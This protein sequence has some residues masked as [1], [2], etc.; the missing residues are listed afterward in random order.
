LGGVTNKRL[1]GKNFGRGRQEKGVIPGGK[2]CKWKREH[3]KEF[4]INSNAKG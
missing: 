4:A 3:I 2:T 1:K